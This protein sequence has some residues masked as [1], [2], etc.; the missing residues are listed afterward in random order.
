MGFTIFLFFQMTFNLSINFI[1][2]K[3]KR[4]SAAITNAANKYTVA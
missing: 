4:I 2:C 1:Q 3:T